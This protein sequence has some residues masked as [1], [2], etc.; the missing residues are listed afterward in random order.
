[1]PTPLVGSV[2]DRGELINFDVAK[3]KDAS[4]HAVSLVHATQYSLNP[5][6]QFRRVER[7][8]SIEVV[9]YPQF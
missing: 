5:R 2:R 4:V 7:L 3:V 1:M 8:V 6:G 9:P